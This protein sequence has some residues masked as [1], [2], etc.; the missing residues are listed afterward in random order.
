MKPLFIFSHEDTPN[1]D[2][3][4]LRH[5]LICQNRLYCASETLQP[6]VEVNDDLHIHNSP[7]SFWDTIEYELKIDVEP[8]DIA[9]VLSGAVRTLGREYSISSLFHQKSFEKHYEIQT[10]T[11]S[12]HAVRLGKSSWKMQRP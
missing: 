11:E 5:I 12:I 6:L 10:D 9:T 7:N 1:I 8:C 2:K 3:S 4:E